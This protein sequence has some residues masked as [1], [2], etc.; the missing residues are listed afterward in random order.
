MVSWKII[1]S[2][3][4]DEW[5]DDY[6][7]SILADPIAPLPPARQSIGSA[8]A[9]W[10]FCEPG[11]AHID[12]T[13]GTSDDRRLAEIVVRSQLKGHGIRQAQYTFIQ[14]HRTSTWDDIMAKAKRLIQSGNVTLLRNGAQNV[15]ANVIGDTGQYQSEFS[16]EDPQSQAMTQW[17]CSCPWDQ[18]AFQ[19][20]RQWKK[21]EGR[22]CAHVL[23][24]WWKSSATPLDEEFN[25]D[26]EQG[27]QS[28]FALPTGQGQPK[29]SPFAA[30]TPGAQGEQLPIPGMFPGEAQG[31]APGPSVGMPA[32]PGVIP[33]YPL[34]PS[35][36]PQVA[37]V[38]VPGLKQP[39]PTNPVQ[40]PGG[41]FSSWRSGTID[42]MLVN[43]QMVST[44]QDD[45]GS[46][47]GVS[48]AHGAGQPA[49]I[50]K[51]DVGEVLGTDPTTGM[52]NVLFEGRGTA[53]MGNL[54]PHGITGW[55]FPS[56]I[57]HRPDVKAPGPAVRRQR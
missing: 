15:I 5:F 56:E 20:T 40:Y 27:Q 33:P 38:S 10:F 1:S 45:W 52:I 4:E 43:G 44:K 34:D 35:Q 28:L 12:T 50:K 18:Y 55:F 29:V 6:I 32:D 16:R 3:D 19:R 36:M 22:P 9:S 39:S 24:T 30:P 2:Q 37:P 41:T 25:P 46:F 21:Y 48:D 53:Q 7:G 26:G 8:N 47:V 57:E 42:P 23:A 49:K 17:Q 14:E 13:G 54:E 31:T 51:G 11:I